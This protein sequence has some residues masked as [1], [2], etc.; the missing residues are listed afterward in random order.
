MPS[1]KVRHALPWLQHASLWIVLFA[2]WSISTSSDAQSDSYRPRFGDWYSSD[3]KQVLYKVRFD[4]FDTEGKAAKDIEFEFN[5]FR[6]KVTT[7]SKLQANQITAWLKLYKDDSV[8]ELFVKTKDGRK[9][10]RFRM[11]SHDLRRHCEMGVRIQL[12]PIRKIKVLV[13]DHDSIPIANALIVEQGVKT[14]EQGVARVELPAD[15]KP[16]R[17]MVL[18]PR[19]EVGRLDL[20]RTPEKMNDIEFTVRT[21]LPKDTQ[22]QTLVIVDENGS[23]VPGLAISPQPRDRSVTMVPDL[24]FPLYSDS[25]GQARVTWIPGLP[26]PKGFIAIYERDWIVEDDERTPDKWTVKLKKLKRKKITGKIDLPKG[27]QG[28]FLVQ[29]S[30]YDHPT[31]RRIDRLNVRC[32]AQGKFEAH[33]IPEAAYCVYVMDARWYSTFWDGVPVEED[34]SV[35][36]PQLKIKR[37]VPL[38]IVAT[39]CNDKAPLVEAAVSIEREMLFRSKTGRGLSSAGPYLQY[40]PDKKGIVNAFVSPGEV[41]VTLRSSGFNEAKTIQ[42]KSEDNEVVRFHGD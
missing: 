12:E 40:R 14:D 16:T 20:Y 4:V 21:V 23:S 8:A 42:V 39:Q 37:G 19:G 11:M 27:I 22:K 29:L 33:V 31:D 25:K 18:G 10:K 1:I 30:S 34:G 3:G 38:K 5:R 41:K 32:D 15:E 2:V 35:S 36:V 13:T 9:G 17:F 28:G 26:G 6:R 24:G 7:K